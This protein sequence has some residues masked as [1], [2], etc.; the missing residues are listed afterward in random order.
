M[1]GKAAVMAILLI[2]SSAAATAAE[3]TII[4]R[5][6]QRKP[7]NAASGEPATSETGQFVV[8]RSAATN[9]DSDRCKN[10]FTHIFVR[11]R[12]TGTIRCVSVNSNDRQGDRDSLA[13]SISADGRFIA[14]TSPATNLDE[15][16][17]DN[18]FHQIYVRDRVSGTTRCISVNSNDRNGNQDSHASSISDDGRFIAFDSAATNLTGNKCDNG[19]NH[20]FVHDRST[21]KTTCVSVRSNGDEANGDSFDPSISADGR[22]VV[23]S[24]A[25]NLSARCDNGNSHIYIHNLDTGENHCLSRNNEGQQSNGNSALAR[26]SGDGRFVVFQSDSTNVTRRCVNGA[27]QIFVRDLVE[28]RI[29]CASIDNRGN[30]GNDDSVQPSISSDGRFVAFSSGATNLTGNRCADGI[31]QVFVRDRLDEKTACASVGPKKVKG[32][33]AST[34]PSIA[35]NGSLVTFE[36]D[37]SNLVKKDLNGLRDVFARGISTSSDGDGSSFVIVSDLLQGD[38]PTG[39][40]I[41]I[42]D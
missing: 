27:M 15:D 2:L 14:F 28:G 24:T 42:F 1:K 30:Q 34:S 10:G 38:E 41:L 31:T 22:V 8:F 16:R 36:S 39:G 5:K 7:S 17:C 40:L 3:T 33:G 35:A 6:S 13:P 18:G 32:N 21:G 9:L 26:V 23:F 4:S 12:N 37:A 11:D 19:F 29:T 20:V 25:T